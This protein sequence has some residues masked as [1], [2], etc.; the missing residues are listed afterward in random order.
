MPRRKGRAN[1]EAALDLGGFAVNVKITR[2]AR[3]CQL[4]VL[5]FSP[6]HT[7]EIAE[8]SR[9]LSKEHKCWCET[10]LPETSPPED[11]DHAH[12]SIPRG[13]NDSRLGPSLAPVCPFSRPFWP[14]RRQR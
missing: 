1:R 10:P 13:R 8:S 14:A 5:S 7:A 6:A 9:L 12:R 4:P 2:L 11:R 3:F